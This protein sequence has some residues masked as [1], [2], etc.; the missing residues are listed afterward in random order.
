MAKSSKSKKSVTTDGSVPFDDDDEG[1]SAVLL[2][3]I[4]TDSPLPSMADGPYTEDWMRHGM[5]SEEDEAEWIADR[6]KER[7]NADSSPK[8]RKAVVPPEKLAKG[9][10]LFDYLRKCT[11]PLDKKIID[12][13]NAQMQVPD[14]LKDDSAQ[15][16]RWTWAQMMPDIAK[17]KPGQIASYAHRVARHTAL[18]VRRELGSSVRLPGSA[19]RKKKDGSTYVTP[20]LLSTALQWEELEGWLDADD[21]ADSAYTVQGGNNIELRTLLEGSDIGVVVEDEETENMNHRLALVNAKSDKLSTLQREILIR[22]IK[23]ESYESIQT[24]L[25]LK[26]A[27]LLNEIE[28]ATAKLYRD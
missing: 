16:I 7:L 21:A 8:K 15:E 26:R 14:E 12:I 22:M 10:N 18:R 24:G 4:D 25:K 5:L 1:S 13:A 6:E 19:F 20:G 9:T 27:M 3:D 11:P 28:E 23:G 2:E 17:F